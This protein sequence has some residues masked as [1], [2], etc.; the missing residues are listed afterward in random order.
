MYNYIIFIFFMFYFCFCFKYD[1]YVNL[2]LF[3]YK[4]KWIMCRLK[5]CICIFLVCY[6]DYLL[7]GMFIRYCLCCGYFVCLKKKNNYLFDK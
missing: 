2:K 1:V 6:L 3:E 4:E 5:G 7:L